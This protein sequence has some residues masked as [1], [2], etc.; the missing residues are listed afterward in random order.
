MEQWDPG[1]EFRRF[2]QAGLSLMVINPPGKP[3]C[4]RGP[5]LSPLISHLARDPAALRGALVF[6]KIVGAA[7]ALLLVYGE[8]GEVWTPRASRSALTVLMRYRL[9]FRV[10]ELVSFIPNSAGDGPCPFEALAGAKNPAEF[11]A[12]MVS[13]RSNHAH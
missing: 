1:G 12:H 10:Q 8:A 5:G 4:A 3:S 13:R 2:V 7:A 9:P 11:Y 6:D